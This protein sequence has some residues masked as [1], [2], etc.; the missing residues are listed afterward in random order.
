MAKILINGFLDKLE[1]EF[2]CLAMCS[3]CQS[4][5]LFNLLHFIKKLIDCRD[6][7]WKWKSRAGSESISGNFGSWSWEAVKLEKLGPS[8]WQF[9]RHHEKVIFGLQ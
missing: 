3:L 9:Y 6:V 1:H 4:G 8:S 7:T 5:Q 2:K